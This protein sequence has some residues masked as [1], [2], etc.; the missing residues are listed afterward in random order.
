MFV[1]HQAEVVKCQA[2][3]AGNLEVVVTFDLI[4]APSSLIN[5]NGS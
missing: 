3:S 1:L 2:T 4:P 5:F